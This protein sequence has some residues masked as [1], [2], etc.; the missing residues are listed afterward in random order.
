MALCYW[1][2]AQI[3]SPY[4]A[5]DVSANSLASPPG[6]SMGV[7]CTL[8][9]PISWSPMSPWYH[10]L[11]SIHN[12]SHFP[13]RAKLFHPFAHSL[14]KIAFLPCLWGKPTS[15]SQRPFWIHPEQ[16]PSLPLL[17]HL[18]IHTVH[19]YAPTALF[20][21]CDYRPEICCFCCLL[22]SW[23]L[24]EYFIGDANGVLFISEF[25]IM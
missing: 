21:N 22:S 15:L 12:P 16:S 18:H 10:P 24:N 6:I 4:T 2:K 19:S 20:N 11:C 7:P 14:P 13:G 1:G 17:C 9:Q 23:A 3:L 25:P 5:K 8:L